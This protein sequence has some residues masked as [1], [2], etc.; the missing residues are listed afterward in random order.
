MALHA[1][2]LPKVVDPSTKKATTSKPA[3]ARAKKAATPVGG[4][5]TKIT[6]PTMTKKGQGSFSVLGTPT[7]KVSSSKVTRRSRVILKPVPRRQ[8]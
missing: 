6:K 3:A 4:R 2:L 7:T 5:A 1:A 8:H